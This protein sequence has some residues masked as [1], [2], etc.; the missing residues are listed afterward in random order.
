MILP[1]D[2]I[3]IFAYASFFAYVRH[4][5]IHV[6]LRTQTIFRAQILAFL[7]PAYAKS[8]FLFFFAYAGGIIGLFHVEGK[9]NATGG[10][11][12]IFSARTSSNML[13]GGA[14]VPPVTDI[15][16]PLRLNFGLKLRYLQTFTGKFDIILAGD[17]R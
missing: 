11:L 15:R 12:Y 4:F 16:P 14:I 1:W 3:L 5:G 13:T 6:S 17:N 8:V 2:R 7:P 9:I 10:M